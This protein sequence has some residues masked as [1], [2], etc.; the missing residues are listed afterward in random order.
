M[1]V[2]LTMVTDDRE[3]TAKGLAENFQLSTEE[4]LEVPQVLLGSVDEICDQLVARRDQFGFS[5]IIV[6]DSGFETLAPVIDRLAGT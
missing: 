4:A 1:Q 3:A 2:I 5:Y 6:N